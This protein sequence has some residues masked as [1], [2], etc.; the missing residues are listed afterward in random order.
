MFGKIGNDRYLE[1]S[2]DILRSG[3]HLLEVINSVLDIAKTETGKMAIQAEPVDLG[4]ILIE[5]SRMIRDQCVAGNVALRLESILQPLIVNGE[6]AKLRQIFLNLLSNACKFTEPDGQIRIRG[7]T[8]EAGM[9]AVE[10][11]DTGIGMSAQDIA[12]A[13]TP[14]G[15]VDNRL[16]R[17][18]EGTGLGLPLTKALV[19]LHRGTFV[20]D[21]EPG[22]GTTVTVRLPNAGIASGDDDLIAVAV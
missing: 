6:K 10:V 18:Y 9:I 1:Y 19:E 22:R 5:C 2:S 12:I 14:F 8:D 3:R 15:Q 20:I 16:E 4:N 7:Y 13:L 11:K 17:R 21:S